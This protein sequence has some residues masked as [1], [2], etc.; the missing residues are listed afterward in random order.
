MTPLVLGTREDLTGFALA[1]VGGMICTTVNDVEHALSG[2]GDESIVILSSAAAVLAAGAIA[3]WEKRG[4]GP[5]FV[6]LPAR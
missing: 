5:L 4:T 6:V 2:T 3:E 1:G